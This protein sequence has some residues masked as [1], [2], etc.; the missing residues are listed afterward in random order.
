MGPKNK[1][2]AIFLIVLAFA[3][4]LM[5][6]F[7]TIDYIANHRTFE[8]GVI[9]QYASIKIK[10]FFYILKSVS[11]ISSI[12]VPGSPP[13]PHTPSEKALTLKCTPKNPP[14]KFAAISEAIPC[15]AVMKSDNKNFFVRNIEI[16]MIKPNI[17][18]TIYIAVVIT[19]SPS[20]AIL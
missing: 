17:P 13:R 12:T 11:V 2:K 7:G 10:R 14:I 6:V 5:L 3:V 16:I 18:R 15:K 9:I 19:F 4:S 1:F 20:Y 8:S